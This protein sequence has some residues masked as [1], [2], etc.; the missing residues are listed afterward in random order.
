MLQAHQ[1]RPFFYYIKGVLQ[2][3]IEYR[4]LPREMKMGKDHLSSTFE[5]AL[6]KAEPG[7]VLLRLFVAGL[8]PR[9]QV[10]ISTLRKLCDER[11]DGNYRLE[12][13]DISQQTELARQHQILA[14]PTL[15]RYLPEPKKVMI[16]DFSRTERLLACLGLAA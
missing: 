5:Q 7:I 6:S 2:Q 14:T 4:L 13:V 8:T 11:L 3:S 10:A 15:V 12:I 1:Q 9:S 16:G